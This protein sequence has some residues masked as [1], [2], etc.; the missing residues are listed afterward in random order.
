MIVRKI[1]AIKIIRDQIQMNY[2]I[3]VGL[4]D[5]KTIID[6][7][8]NGE[9]E[10]AWINGTVSDKELIAYAHRQL[11]RY[12]ALRHSDNAWASETP[13]VTYDA[14]EELVDEPF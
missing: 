13:P 10:E 11:S 5:A 1:Q 14:N 3:V 2:G 4:K 9:L 7:I 8:E 12:R 6:L